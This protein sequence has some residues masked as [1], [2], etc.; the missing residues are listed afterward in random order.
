MALVK[1]FKKTV[2]GTT[3]LTV[4]MDMAVDRLGIDCLH[5]IEKD[6]D[7]ELGHQGFARQTTE[8]GD[9]IVFKYW[10]FGT[11]Y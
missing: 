4:T 11:C 2:G 8:K 3:V 9:R 1:G 5:S 7:R 6:L 10:Q